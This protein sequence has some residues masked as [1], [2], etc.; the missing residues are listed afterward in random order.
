VLRIFNKS[1]SHPDPPVRARSRAGDVPTLLVLKIKL[2]SD[3]SIDKMKARRCVLG[4]RHYL[5]YSRG[6]FADEGV[7]PKLV[8]MVLQKR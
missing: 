3:G 4:Y 1:L 8:C 6:R 7:A 5:D 2:A